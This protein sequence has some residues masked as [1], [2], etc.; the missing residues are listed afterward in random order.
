M[1]CRYWIVLPFMAVGCAPQS[2][3]MA[4]S[5][6]ER[7]TVV[8]RGPEGLREFTPVRAPFTEGGECTET[9]L[10]NAKRLS[11]HFPARSEPEMLIVLLTDGS[12]KILRYSESRGV[13]QPNRNLTAL[14]AEMAGMR[15]THIQLDYV[16]GE[17]MATN[18][19]PGEPGRTIMGS[20]DDFERSSVLGDIPARAAMAGRIC[21]EQ[22]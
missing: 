19:G 13:P 22:H 20:V 3:I 4:M 8:G 6:G 5:R 16:T 21:A 10:P 12:G 2:P 15:R 7:T 1:Q 9:D 18:Y 17:A 14:R 11:V